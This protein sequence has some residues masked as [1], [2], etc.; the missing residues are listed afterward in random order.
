M[1]FGRSVTRSVGTALD[2][3]HEHPGRRSTPS[4]III[5][6]HDILSERGS[7]RSI[8]SERNTGVCDASVLTADWRVFR[9]VLNVEHEPIMH[10]T[11]HH[12]RL[13]RATTARS[14]TGEVL[15]PVTVRQL[16]PDPLWWCLPFFLDPDQARGDDAIIGLRRLV[17]EAQYEPEPFGHGSHV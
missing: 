16:H 17:L 3:G 2:G 4:T 15:R 7:R 8:P 6:F 14:A 11:G 10:P 13:A 12:A 9:S 5:L 1:V